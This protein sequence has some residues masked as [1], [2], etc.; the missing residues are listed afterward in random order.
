MGRAVASA[1]A[2]RN[3]WG[4]NGWRKS[5]PQSPLP[6]RYH[7]HLLRGL[8]R[9]GAQLGTAHADP[10]GGWRESRQSRFV[11][12]ISRVSGLQQSNVVPLP[13]SS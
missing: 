5:S 9:S 1:T 10:K 3:C 6:M 2:A 11:A 13:N 8:G 4:G 12:G 7:V